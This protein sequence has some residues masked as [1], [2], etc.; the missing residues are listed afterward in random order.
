MTALAPEDGACASARNLPCRP[1]RM[2]TPG[3]QDYPQAPEDG[4][5]VSAL[6]SSHVCQ[7]IKLRHI[8]L[9]PE[10]NPFRH[11]GSTSLSWLHSTLPS[12]LRIQHC[13][14]MAQRWFP[15]GHTHLPLD[16]GNPYHELCSTTPFSAHSIRPAN[17][18][19]HQRNCMGLPELAAL[20]ASLAARLAALA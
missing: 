7:K 13:S 20:L 12:N 15:Q 3:I 10:G 1:L 14:R 5:R 6:K 2:N 19:I 11:C 18:Q 4:T 16:R 8:L 17:S 9:L